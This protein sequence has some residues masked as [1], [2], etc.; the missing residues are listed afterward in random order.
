M[1]MDAHIASLFPGE[2][3]NLAVEGIVRATAPAEPR[4]RVSLSMRSLLNTKRLI[5]LVAGAQKWALC[6][7]ILDGADRDTPLAKLIELAGE[8][9]ELHIVDR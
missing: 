1:G 5:L 9:L 6:Q 3:I 2:R 7:A 8:K 4:E